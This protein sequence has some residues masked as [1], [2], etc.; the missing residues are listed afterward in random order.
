MFNKI[1]EYDILVVNLFVFI[2]YIEWRI[3]PYSILLITY[4][5]AWLIEAIG[6]FYLYSF[7]EKKNNNTKLDIYK[8]I[9]LTIKIWIS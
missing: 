1:L 9:Y 2:F 4:S 6:I 3:I 7:L 5:E 8:L